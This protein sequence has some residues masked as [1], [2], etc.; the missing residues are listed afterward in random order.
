[1]TKSRE[2]TLICLLLNVKEAFDHVALKQLIKILIKLKI[3]INLINWVK[4]FL[5]NQVIDLAFDDKSQKSKKII[6]EI[7][8]DSFISLILFLIYIWYLFSKIRAKIENLQLFSYIDDVALYMKKKNI[9]KNVKTLENVDWS[10]RVE[11]LSSSRVG[12]FL[13][14]CRVELRS[15]TQALESSWEAWLDNSTRKL[16]STRQDIR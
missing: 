16:D 14:K 11:Y 12:I 9:D 4:C 10:R 15:W 2:N 7:S 13:K 6:T 8:Q 3:S 1:M 5:Q